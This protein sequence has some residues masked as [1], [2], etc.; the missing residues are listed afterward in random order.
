M[1]K[2][3]SFLFFFVLLSLPGL[4]QE[5]FYDP[6]QIQDIRL[7]VNGD[8]WRYQLDSLRFNGD[9]NLPARAIIL[10]G[11][12][13]PGGG[14]RYRDSQAFTP[15]EPRNDL[16]VTLSAGNPLGQATLFLSSALRD[17][18]L[19]R[20]VTALEILRQYTPAPRA[21]F[22]R[23]YVNDEYYGLFV[24][25]EPIA[26]SFLT[27]SFG[28]A[29]GLLYR[30]VRRVDPP[31]VPAVCQKITL[32][33]LGTMPEPA[34]Y[35]RFYEIV[36]GQDYQ[37]LQD[38]TVR[39]A[40]NAPLPGFLDTDAALWMLAFNNL[41]VSLYGYSGGFS[42]NYFLYQRPD[43]IWSPLVGDMN[44]AFGSFKSPDLK[45]SDLSIETLTQ[46]SP[47]LY[48]EAADRPLISRLLSDPGY[49]KTYLSFYRTLLEKFF[50]SGAFAERVTQ[51]QTMIQP[52]LAE[53]RNWYYGPE[54]FQASRETVVGKRSQIPGVVAFMRDRTNWLK[55]QP[56][57]TVQ[58]PT[59]RNI[60][61]AERP[62]FSREQLT[63]YRITAELSDYATAAQ[64]HYQLGNGAWQS[65]EMKDDGA[66][67]DGAAG[68]G[69]FGVVVPAR[70]QDINYYLEAENRATKQFSPNNFRF[71]TH[72]SSLAEINE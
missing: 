1:M 46:L 34:C 62:Q 26:D 71:T 14:V 64:L 67:Q 7:V 18:S 44:L 22:A 10:N 69:V 4:A 5:S 12:E 61:V 3:Y 45:A 39:L 66:H 60:A 8:N 49:R 50:V 6:D 51:L 56:V 41:T 23:V 13:L 54:A 65:A 43:G 52:A 47:L 40:S 25:R 35:A 9:E 55:T 32:N 37:P 48:A 27:R 19:V 21:N 24:N 33:T 68:D 59:I 2:L 15:G 57:Y 16:I 63:E 72:R 42:S 11:T 58:P 53:D 36:Q 31:A 38:F 30:A 20:E 29:N 17:P 28:N 70:G